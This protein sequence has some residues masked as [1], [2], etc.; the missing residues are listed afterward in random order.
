LKVSALS[1]YLFGSLIAVS[2]LSCPGAVAQGLPVTQVW[3]AEIE[4]G[5]PGEPRLISAASGYNNQ[6]M[7]SADGK[8]I[9]FTAEQVDGQTDI[10]RFNI[11]SD[12]LWLVNRSPESEYSP[13]PIP[14]RNAV[15]VIRVEL[16]DQIQRLWSLSLSED[17]A[18]LLIPN[19]EPVGYHS[20]IDQQSV[21]VFIL[22]DS[23]TLHRATVGDQPSI[24]LADHI[25]RTIRKHPKSGETL[26]VSKITE[27]WSISSIDTVTGKQTKVMSLYPETED[28][29]VDPSG[30]FWMGYGSK[31]Y[32][33]SNSNNRWELAGDL[34]EFGIDNITRLAVS[35]DGNRIAI[36]ASP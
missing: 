2:F 19:V 34:R 31:L 5:V 1:N 29:E 9:F 6:P 10:A 7:F 26:F 27:P 3:L 21:A 4:S 17:K 13:T 32:R 18:E 15:S 16:P 25:G 8:E 22:G 35:P 12:D 28:F 36:V 24:Q 14:G 11:D 30:Q 33:S 20:W 23:F